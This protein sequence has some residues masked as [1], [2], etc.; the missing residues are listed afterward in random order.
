MIVYLY[1]LNIIWVVKTLGTQYTILTQTYLSRWTGVF[2]VSH[3]HEENLL[4]KSSNMML[5][6]LRKCGCL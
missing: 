4:I 1:F 3:S 6:E 5:Y 2:R